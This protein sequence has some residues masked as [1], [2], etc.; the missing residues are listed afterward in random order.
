MCL[1]PR[2]DA[3]ITGGLTCTP[4]HWPLAY[5]SVKDTCSNLFWGH[6]PKFL[7]DFSPLTS[8]PVLLISVRLNS[9]SW[10]VPLVPQDLY[11]LGFS[12]VTLA[13]SAR[14]LEVCARSVQLLCHVLSAGVQSTELLAVLWGHAAVLLVLTCRVSPVIR[15]CRAHAPGVQW[16]QLVV[17]VFKPMSKPAGRKHC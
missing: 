6:S 11:L 17:V 1:T 13:M 14:S 15:L 3:S 5:F 12:S 7:S 8:C 16:T 4:Q 10:P 9:I 2:W